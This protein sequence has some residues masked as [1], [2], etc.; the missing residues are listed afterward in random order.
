[1]R[2]PVEVRAT[3]SAWD[4]GR[5][6]DCRLARR[7]QVNH[8]Y[9]IRSGTGKY[10]LRHVT[11]NVHHNSD[12]D[13]E[14]ELEYLKEL[15]N[16]GFEYG[17]PSPVLTREGDLFKKVNGVYYWF[18]E[19]LEGRVVPM[20]SIRQLGQ[21]AKMMASYH[22]LIEKS[23]IRNG[24]KPGDVF[25]RAEI[26]ELM[27]ENRRGIVR[28]HRKD[29]SDSVFIRESE[30]IERLLEDLDDTAYRDLGR[31]PIHRD[32]I[33]ENLLW[34]KDKLVGLIDFEHVS[35]SDEAVVKDIAVTMQFCCR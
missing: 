7:G 4:I 34:K 23:G 1:M 33:P 25:S 16:A 5:V 2:V 3:L 22:L 13:L 17:L 11:P 21:L 19:F 20:L 24:K 9:I 14:F 10:V 12:G 29:R 28:E 8:N 31:Y 30:K 35:S 6:L 27:E 15:K 18:Y 32:I 26:L